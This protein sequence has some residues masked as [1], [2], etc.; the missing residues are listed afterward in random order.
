MS[1]SHFS[2]LV[3]ILAISGPRKML[4]SLLLII[5]S[6]L[7]YDYYDYHYDD[8]YYYDYFYEEYGICEGSF[9][10]YESVGAYVKNET[11]VAGTDLVERDGTWHD[12][13]IDRWLIVVEQRIFVL[14]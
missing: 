14:S 3:L 13:T 4:I 8:F 1:H 11:P 6:V 7:S 5:P 10:A 9:C 12:I 2:V